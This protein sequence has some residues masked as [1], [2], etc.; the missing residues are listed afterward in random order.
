MRLLDLVQ[1]RLVIAQM[2][3]R[4]KWDAIEELVD[5]LLEEHEIR[6]FE[7]EEVLGA[8]LQRERGRS[9]GLS[10]GVAM[11]H[12]RIQT[13]QDPVAVLGIAPG[14]IPFE[15]VDDRDAEVIFLLLIPQAQYSDHIK[16][17]ADVNRLLANA[18]FRTALVDAARTGGARQILDLLETTEGPGFLHA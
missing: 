5:K 3:S 8:V 7:R 6:I 2:R 11:P 18:Q 1:G 12:A 10:D 13:L 4:N 9:T 16:T 14:G 17:L 15:S